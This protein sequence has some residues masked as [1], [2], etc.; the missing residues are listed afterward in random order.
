MLMP[1]L[2]ALHTALI[3]AAALLFRCHYDALLRRDDAALPDT[4][5]DLFF[6]ASRMR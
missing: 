5:A 3:A 4:A 6:S 1:P 2:F